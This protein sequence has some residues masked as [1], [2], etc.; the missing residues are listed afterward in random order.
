MIELK[1]ETIA[2]GGLV[3]RLYDEIQKAVAN[4]LDVN[5]EAKK[6]RT[7]SLK[8]KIKPDESR[9]FATMSVETSSTLCPPSPLV[10]SI[11]METNLATGEITAH[12]MGADENPNQ[13]TLPDVTVTA[14]KITNFNGGK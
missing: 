5:T 7:V 4:C 8:V 1:P 13:N 3:E 10:S 14:G 9:C 12:E 11:Y 6:T 2:N